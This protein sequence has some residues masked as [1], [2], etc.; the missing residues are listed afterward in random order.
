VHG[1]LIDHSADVS[2]KEYDAWVD[3]QQEEKN[4]EYEKIA[5]KA[6]DEFMEQQIDALKASNLGDEEKGLSE[7]V[8]LDGG[9]FTFGSLDVDE[10]GFQECA[11]DTHDAAMSP[12]LPCPPG[13]LADSQPKAGAT[14]AVSTARRRRQ[15]RDGEQ[16]R[17]GHEGADR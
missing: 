13:S 10:D 16:A 9:W 11:C 3:K 2:E 8:P 7:Q 17:R 14:E 12:H 1:A 6:R 15:G 5:S 4:K